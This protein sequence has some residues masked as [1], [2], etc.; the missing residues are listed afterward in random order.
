MSIFVSYRRDDTTAYAGWLADRLDERFGDRKVFRDIDSIEPGL[1]FLVAMERALA[2]CEVMLVVVGK[3]WAT[4][5]MEKERTRQEDYTR[6]EVTTAL[7]GNVR[8]I[9]VLVQGASMPGAAELPDDLAALTRRNAIELHDTNWNSDVQNLIDKLERMLP[10]SVQEHAQLSTVQPPRSVT[11]PDGS[12]L[13]IV[14]SFE[15]IEYLCKKGKVLV[16]VNDAGLKFV[17]GSTIKLV[18]REFVP[19]LAP[20]AKANGAVLCFSNVGQPFGLGRN[21]FAKYLKDRGLKHLRTSDSYSSLLFE[22]GR[23]VG[24]RKGKWL[25]LSYD[26]DIEAAIELLKG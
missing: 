6:L 12:Q 4:Q 2:T 1:D 19:R 10:I 25:A 13:F 8:V 16:L 24:Y 20:T 5:L 26:R 22:N 18:L 23:L 9:P 15:E 11:A 21:D 3:N 17:E 14:N 7:K